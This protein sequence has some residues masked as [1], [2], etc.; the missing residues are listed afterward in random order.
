[1]HLELLHHA[2]AKTPAPPRAPLL[3][4]HGA[5]CGAW[6]W[7]E[8]FLP[9]FAEQGFD[10]WAVSLRGHG[11]SAGHEALAGWG[12]NDY[13]AD[14]EQAIATIGA[15]PVLIGHS[16]GG[17]V[18]Q[19]LLERRRPPAVVLMSSVPPQGLTAV[20]GTM[21]SL[22]PTLLWE[23]SMVQSFGPRGISLATMQRAMF[24]ENIP[25]E[26]SERYY[27]RL[28]SESHRVT[29]D[30]AGPGLA[31]LKWFSL[32]PMLVV[33]AAQDTFIPPTLNELTALTFGAEKEILPQEAHAMMLGQRWI[34][35]AERLKRFFDDHG[36]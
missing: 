18:V 34:V 21:L 24:A 15:E 31:A 20:L 17:M 12:L 14:V 29:I 33:G 26:Q 36:V 28:Q 4:V 2:P 23:A 25:R 3:F 8:Y 1:M 35:A 5:F 32:P 27:N 19:K 6:I 16:M 7:E 13:A 9:W 22:N 30:M 10:A 11:E